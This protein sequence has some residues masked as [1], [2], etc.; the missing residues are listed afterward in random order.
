MTQTLKAFWPFETSLVPKLPHYLSS[1]AP[2]VH[3]HPKMAWLFP[4]EQYD[5]T[6]KDLSRGRLCDD[7]R[8]KPFRF[9]ELPGELRNLIYEC[10]TDGLMITHNPFDPAVPCMFRY[11]MIN[12]Q[13]L[14]FDARPHPLTQVCRQIRS[15]FLPFLRSDRAIANMRAAA[16]VDYNFGPLLEHLRRYPAIQP[17]CQ[18]EIQ[19]RFTKDGSEN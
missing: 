14:D 7:N 19:L 4:S 6:A 10:A 2:L 17:P 3:W 12:G 15:E 8:P 11:L 1:S 13:L 18:L 9:L 5:V 16:V